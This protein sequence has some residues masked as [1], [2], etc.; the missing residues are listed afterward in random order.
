[1]WFLEP[2]KEEMNLMAPF[3]MGIRNSFQMGKFLKLGRPSASPVQLLIFLVCCWLTSCVVSFS[4]PLDDYFHEGKSKTLA[5]DIC[6][7]KGKEF[8]CINRRSL[9]RCFNPSPYVNISVSTEGP[10]ADEQNITVTVSGVKHPRDHDFVALISPTTAD[11]TECPQN[12]IKYIETGDLK[13]HPLLCHYPVKAQYLNND[14]SYIPCSKTTCQKYHGKKCKVKTCS[15]S[16]TFNV[17]NIRTDIEFVFFGGGFQVPCI[18]KRTQPL[19]FS[20]PAMPL[21]AHL[22][23]VDSTGTTMKVVW[24]SADSRKQFVQYGGIKQAESTISTFTQADMCSGGKIKSAAKDFGWHDPGYIHTAIMTELL[25][26]QTYIYR[27]GSDTV[28]WSKPDQFWTPPAAGSSELRFIAFGDMGHAPIDPSDEHFIQKGSLGVIRAIAEDVAARK[29]DSVFHIGDISYATGFLVEWDHFLHMIT[30]VASHLSYMTAIG[31]HER[32][33]D[34]SGAYYGTPDSGGECGVPYEKYFPMPTP[35][36]DKPWYSI[37]Q[38]PVHFTVISSENDWTKNS[39]QYQWMK[40][41][42]ASVD[43][44]KTPWLIFCG[45]R[46]MYSTAKTGLIALIRPGVDPDFVSTVEPL[47]L[48]FQVDLVLWGHV[49]NYE[50]T[51][52]VFNETCKALPIKD[53]EG[54]DT[55]DT[56]EYTAPVHVIVGT[57]G[58]SLDTFKDT[59]VSWSLTRISDYGF[60]RIHAI[61]QQIL[62]Q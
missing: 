40:Q 1:N 4:K 61:N 48:Q 28:G 44:K 8:R 15:A 45:H 42:L 27:Y 21:H 41:D 11:I 56:T 22:S 19:K 5:N 31:N 23:S 52:S 26:S 46:P 17:I 60:A 57:G 14:P 20:N 35:A 59:S 25:P 10:L 38:G 2:F 3:E 39:E 18:H 50:R 49:H 43:R 29:V 34:D 12:K 58:F 30:P 36:Q 62:F 53:H 16:I 47:L 32:D 51:C 33:F 37:N 55:Y 13:S 6:G 24:I 7:E 9:R 54:I